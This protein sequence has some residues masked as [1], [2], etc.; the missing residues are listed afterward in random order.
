[1]GFAMFKKE[2]IK[3]VNLKQSY[4]CFGTFLYVKFSVT[5]H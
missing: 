3:S 5:S 1:M 4:F 2:K